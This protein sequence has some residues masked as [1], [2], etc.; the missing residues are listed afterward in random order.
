V[1]KAQTRDFY[2][3]SLTKTFT[4][5]MIM[6]FAHEKKLSLNDYLL[7]Y[8]FLSSALLRIGFRTRTAS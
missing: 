6:Q 1:L 2:A 7:D 4:A 3:A 5:V 8:P